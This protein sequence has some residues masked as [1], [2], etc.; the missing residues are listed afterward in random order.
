MMGERIMDYGICIMVE[1]AEANEKIMDYEIMDHG[2]WAMGDECV[3]VGDDG[4]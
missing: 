1:M 4:N 3:R 2:L